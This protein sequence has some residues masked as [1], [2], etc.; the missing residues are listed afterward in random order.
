MEL[1]LNV[2]H[3]SLPPTVRESVE[4]KLTRLE[5]RVPPEAVVEVMLDRERGGGGAN[6]HVIDV[7]V[8]L[9]GGNV[10]ARA[11]GSTYETAADRVVDALDRR[12]EKRRDKRVHEPRRRV[13]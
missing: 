11:G 2:R 3:G 10:V 12:L 6:D 8:H 9:K 7:E 13:S 4:R 1:Q 5:R